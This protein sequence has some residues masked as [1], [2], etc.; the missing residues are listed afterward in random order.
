MKKITVERVPGEYAVWYAECAAAGIS[1]ASDQSAA[2]A[3]ELVRQ[4]LT[5]RK[6]ERALGLKGGE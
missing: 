6:V 3:V 5:L 2:R 1:A 4:K